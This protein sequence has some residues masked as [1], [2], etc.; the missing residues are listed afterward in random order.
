MKVLFL[1]IETS[2]NVV[3][4]FEKLSTPATSSVEKL[5]EPSRI[6]VVGYK[7]ADDEPQALSEL[8]S[9]QKKMITTM[10]DLLDEADTVAHYNG[11]RFDVPHLNRAFVE[12]GMAPPSTYRQVDL[13]QTVRRM[14]N[15]P[16]NRLQ[17][18]AHWLRTNGKIEDEKDMHEEF[19]GF[20]L[21]EAALA[22]GRDEDTK[23]R[24]MRAFEEMITYCL[25]DVRL[26]QEVYDALFAYVP[27]LPNAAIY[28]DDELMRCTGCGSTDLVKNG[29]YRTNAGAFQRYRCKVC[30]R[31]SRSSTRI[32][33]TPLRPL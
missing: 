8:V 29:L 13:Y 20:S 16:S 12:H 11:T 17:Y 32:E 3:Y 24:K 14:F 7:W 9:G 26:T 4:R 27:N 23:Q 21:W 6:L 28:E 25:Q 31:Q 18:V 1:D 10:R 30:F 22:K 15:L 33:T 2:P 19:P 5:I